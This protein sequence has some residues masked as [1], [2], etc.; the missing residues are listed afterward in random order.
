MYRSENLIFSNWMLDSHSSIATPTTAPRVQPD[1][2][3]A[4]D[5]VELHLQQHFLAE[6]PLHSE[7]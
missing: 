2:P 6:S 5:L 7:I 3:S 4:E 1:G